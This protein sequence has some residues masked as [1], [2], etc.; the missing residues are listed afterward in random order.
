L[1]EFCRVYE[2]PATI[3]AKLQKL[4]ILGPHILSLILKEELHQDGELWVGE[5]ADVHDAE[6]C[7][8]A[9]LDKNEN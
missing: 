5:I 9:S 6:A 7:W 4:G 1:T 8:Q 2:L 3:E